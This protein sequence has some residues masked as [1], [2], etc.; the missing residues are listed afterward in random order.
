M[1]GIRFLA[2]LEKQTNLH[3]DISS[4]NIHKNKSYQTIFKIFIENK[5]HIYCKYFIHL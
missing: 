3:D 1:I 4:Y 2:P 5:K